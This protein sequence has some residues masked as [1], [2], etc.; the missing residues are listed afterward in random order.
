MIFN[1][2]KI[3]EKT[4]EWTEKADMTL[5]EYLESISPLNDKRKEQ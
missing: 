2:D 3:I 5:I 4:K 1:K